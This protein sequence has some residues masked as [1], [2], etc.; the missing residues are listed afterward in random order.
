LRKTF[1]L[2]EKACRRGKRVGGGKTRKK[3]NM[4]PR[5]LKGRGEGSCESKGG[6]GAREKRAGRGRGNKSAREF[7]GK[8]GARLGAREGK[9]VLLRELGGQK[10]K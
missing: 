8:V 7:S 10:R 3:K 6:E 5:T 4:Q 1:C 9:K 2:Q